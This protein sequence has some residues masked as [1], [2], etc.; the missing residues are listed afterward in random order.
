MNAPAEKAAQVAVSHAATAPVRPLSE[1]GSKGRAP[2][3]NAPI[4]LK[5]FFAD[6]PGEELTV[7]D[8]ATKFGISFKR[9]RNMLAALSG[10]GL[11]ERVSIYRLKDEQ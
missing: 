3:T 5:K 6:N 1:A 2:R 10:A 11:L 7:E 9:A 4:N 8:T